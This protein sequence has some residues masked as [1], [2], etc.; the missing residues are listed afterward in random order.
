MLARIECLHPHNF[1]TSSDEVIDQPLTES[2]T[3]EIHGSVTTI[4]LFDQDACTIGSLPP[5]KDD[6]DASYVN[7]KC[8]FGAARW[9][10]AS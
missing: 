1:D 9:T 3:S 6:D 5:N 4:G 7:A 8:V 10:S 2:G